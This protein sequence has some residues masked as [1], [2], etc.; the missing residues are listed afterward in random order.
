MSE[1][2][3]MSWSAL[4]KP[5]CPFQFSCRDWMRPRFTE[6]ESRGFFLGGELGGSFNDGVKWITHHAGMFPVGVVN[7]PPL[8]ARLQSRGL[9]HGGSSSQFEGAMVCL[10]HKD[11]AQSV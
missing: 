4:G 2:L 9:A 5:L 3:A 8:V 10:A 7:A 6:S 11:R 1:F